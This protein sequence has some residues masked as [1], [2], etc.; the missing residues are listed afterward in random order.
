EFQPKD[1][2]TDKPLAIFATSVE[3][4]C[5]AASG[6]FAALPTNEM[7]RPDWSGNKYI[8]NF[9]ERNQPGP[10][11]PTDRYCLSVAGTLSSLL[12]QVCKKLC[13]ASAPLADTPS[14]RCIPVSGM[15][16]LSMAL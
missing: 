2:L 12:N 7:L 8:K 10:N 9:L 16:Q 13:R 15:I 1:V 4:G 3:D 5:S 6:A 14:A 11:L